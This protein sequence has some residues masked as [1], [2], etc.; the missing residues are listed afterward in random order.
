[1]IQNREST[2]RGRVCESRAHTAFNQSSG[3]FICIIRVSLSHLLAGVFYCLPQRKIIK[4]QNLLYLWSK[5]IRKASSA[6]YKFIFCSKKIPNIYL[7]VDYL[8]TLIWF[9][10]DSRSAYKTNKFYAKWPVGNFGQKPELH[11]E[12]KLCKVGI[13]NSLCSSTVYFTI[14][15]VI[16]AYAIES[17][18]IY[19]HKL[20]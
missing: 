12:K 16:F 4:P 1:M 17:S 15:K 20:R 5:I 3:G 11:L 18:S 2:S 7:Y 13:S 9:F 8:R 10:E 14:F 6:H 19:F